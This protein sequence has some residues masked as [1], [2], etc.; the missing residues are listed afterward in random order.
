[1]SSEQAFRIL[2]F[3]MADRLEAHDR[4]G[5]FCIY[6]LPASFER[7]SAFKILMRL[8]VDGTISAAEPHKLEEVFQN[9]K[10]IDLVK[11]VKEYVKSQRRGKKSS[12]MDSLQVNFSVNVAVAETQ[13]R[14]LQEQIE[15]LQT[16]H[17][18]CRSIEARISEA[19]TIAENLHQKL[20]FIK[21]QH[22]LADSCSE[23]ETNPSPPDTLQ[24]LQQQLAA[25]LIRR[26][27]AHQR[28][29]K[30][31]ESSSRV[32]MSPSPFLQ[33]MSIVHPDPITQ[34]APSF[35]GPPQHSFHKKNPMQ[36]YMLRSRLTL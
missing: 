6:N 11:K 26:T 22:Q 28:Q 5:I 8:V 19:S 27:Q 15:H 36:T 31:D 2:L 10:R 33:V 17:C 35:L 23:S 1:M 21:E 25:G 34:L 30:D 16:L 3:D 9:I 18:S 13:A 32:K 12:K 14:L 29:S 24:R 20:S 7:E 4:E